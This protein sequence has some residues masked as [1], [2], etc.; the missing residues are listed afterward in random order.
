MNSNISSYELFRLESND[1]YFEFDEEYIKIEE[2][3]APLKKILEVREKS[4]PKHP[5]DA[6]QL[7]FRMVWLDKYFS[8]VA[9]KC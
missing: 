5:E 3:T 4:G 9:F 8:L 2:V 1:L 6:L 7:F